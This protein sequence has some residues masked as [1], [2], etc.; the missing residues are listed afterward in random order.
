MI[1]ALLLGLWVLAA[2]AWHREPECPECA[3]CTRRR[4]D[5]EIVEEKARHASFH[6]M[7]G[8][9]GCPYCEKGKKP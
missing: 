2:L 9:K 7:W 4:V 5:R 6:R 3:H 1:P 8:E